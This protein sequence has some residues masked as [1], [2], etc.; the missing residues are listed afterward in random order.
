M[1]IELLDALA[2]LRKATVSFVMSVLQSPL[3]PHGTTPLPLDRF[4]SNKIHEYLLENS[5]ANSSFIEI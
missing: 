5:R 2:E 3:C 1:N 4:S